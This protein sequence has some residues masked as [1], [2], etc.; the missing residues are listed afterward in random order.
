[1]AKNTKNDET[2]LTAPP[3]GKTQMI[4]VGGK[5][6]STKEMIDSIQDLPEGEEV[7]SEYKTFEPGDV[8]RIIFVSNTTMKAK[9]DGGGEVSAVRII[10]GRGVMCINGDRVVVGAL[11]NQPTL[12]AFSVTCTG[13]EESPKGTYKTFI[14]KKLGAKA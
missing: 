13:T 9:G 8:E 6:L 11:S 7:T 3:D 5:M 12:S 10:D 4:E 1:M 2:S 14:I